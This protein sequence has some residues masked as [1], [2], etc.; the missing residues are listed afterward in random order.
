MTVP[1]GCA[2]PVELSERQKMEAGQWY[3]CLDPELEALRQRARAAVHQHSTL[4]PDQRGALAPALRAILG[5]VGTDCLIEAPVH[6]AYGHNLTLADT[7]YINANC[8]FLDTARLAIGAG[9]MLGPAVQ[10]YC[11]QHHT[12]PAKRAAGLEIAH[13]VPIGSNV[14]IG[15][16]AIVMP[17]V[18]IGDN[19]IVGAGSVV[20]KDVARG[21]RVVGNP[22]RVVG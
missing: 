1:C 8:V 18:T 19:A 15:G 20:L 5:G 4:P 6:I 12:D 22:A 16:G 14:W 9:T 17:G 3:S 21:A 7:V 13:P 11:A 10:I 2:D